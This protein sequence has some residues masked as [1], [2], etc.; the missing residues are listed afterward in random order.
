MTISGRPG[1]PGEMGGDNFPIQGF[2]T[3]VTA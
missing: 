2:V 1:N 3:Y